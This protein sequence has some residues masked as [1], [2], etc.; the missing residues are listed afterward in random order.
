[1]SVVSERSTRRSSQKQ[2]SRS[3]GIQ[4]RYGSETEHQMMIPQFSAAASEGVCHM[5]MDDT[6]GDNT[7]VITATSDFSQHVG[8]ALPY[9]EPTTKV[10][11]RRCSRWLWLI[12]AFVLSLISIASAP[13][14]MVTPFLLPYMSIE[15]PEVECPPDCQG[16]V[17]TM[18]VKVVLLVVALWAVYW[19]SAAADMPRIFLPRVALAFFVLFILFAFWLFFIVR[20][21]LERQVAYSYIV[22]Y[23]TS[24]L[25]VLLY[26]HYISV[27]VLV[28]RSLRPEFT[29]SVLRDPDGELRSFPLGMMSLQ[30]AAVQVLRL[31][32]VHFSSFNRALESHRS[33]AKS[34]ASNVST[35]FKMYDID[36]TGAGTLSEENA[37]AVLE[38]AARRKTGG[39]NERLYEE[40]EWESRIRKRQFRLLGS[41]EDAFYNVQ[42]IFPM[43]SNGQAAITEP[44]DIVN[45][46]KSVYAL[47][48]RPLM[49]YLRA[50]RRQNLHSQEQILEHI[51]NCLA[52][53]ISPRTFLNR[54]TSDRMPLQP[55]I[56]ESKWSIVCDRQASSSI[57]HGLTF[58]LRSH[59]QDND[60][61]VQLVCTVSAL[62]FFNI[63]E[64]SS[65]K[66]NF[67]VKGNGDLMC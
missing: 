14:M 63:T 3:R 62:P 18:C 67:A 7:T 24:L 35:G 28:L 33:R 47:I 32:N 49:K 1:M 44:A 55:S 17:L 30:E 54:F 51:Q 66:R 19:R 57:S 37:R 11:G 12:S 9:F 60:S 25:D 64:Q 22:S 43:K 58:I 10:T 52:H 23:S 53:N 5:D 59:N 31:Y 50:A 56:Q 21:V 6:W 48:Q 2:H 4:K 26:V 8:N 15:W 29:I 42:S 16:Y 65:S 38:A 34:G 46:A 45:A 40:Q 39:H 20:I 41:T 61:C 36:G 27:I 13:L